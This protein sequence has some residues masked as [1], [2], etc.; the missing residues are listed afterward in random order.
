[1]PYLHEWRVRFQEVDR[2]GIINYPR[3]FFAVQNGIED[4]LIE[5]EHPY[6][7]LI[8]EEKIAVPTVHAEADYTGQ[9]KHGDL[10]EVEITPAVG[11]SSIT[12]EATGFVDGEPKFTA[13]QKQVTVDAETADPIS[14]PEGLRTGLE[15]I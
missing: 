6:H 9:I 11:Q 13:V 8:P 12:F 1:M 7:R 5:I 15:R 3:V 14:V 10:V 2:I 4:L